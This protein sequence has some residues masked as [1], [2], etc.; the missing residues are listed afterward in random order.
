MAHC[1][2]YIGLIYPYSINYIE[3]SRLHVI[4]QCSLDDVM[5]QI[6]FI[7]CP[8]SFC[9]CDQHSYQYIT[10]S[11]TIAN[12]HLPSVHI[13]CLSQLIATPSIPQHLF[14][15]SEVL[16]GVVLGLGILVLLG[17]CIHLKFTII[18]IMK[19]V[20]Y[21]LLPFSTTYSSTGWQDF[22]CHLYVQ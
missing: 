20:I 6:L 1:D 21:Y 10:S 14:Q 22:H 4:K 13:S 7:C 8:S 5:V 3:L 9:A 2:N 19:N 11:Y 16:W 12:H 18:H 15:S 17:Y